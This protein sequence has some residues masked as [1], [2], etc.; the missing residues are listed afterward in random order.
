MIVGLLGGTFDP[1][2]VGHLQMARVA[3]WSNKVDKV[4]FLPCWQHAFGKKPT[5]YTYRVNMCAAMLIDADD[6]RMEVWRDEEEI[7]STYSVDI[8]EYIHTKHTEVDEFKLILGA[9]NYWKMNQWKQPSKIWTLA[10]PLWIDRP[11]TSRIPEES[12][13]CNVNISSSQ[14]RE[15]IRRA[16]RQKEELSNILKDE[17]SEKVMQ[18]IYE[19]RLYQEEE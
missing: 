5:D 16:Y 17:M 12:L 9:D 6:S 18:Y 4:A 10:E 11:G 7:K 19:Y 1:P 8:L 3:L 2:H 15:R 14:I 13:V